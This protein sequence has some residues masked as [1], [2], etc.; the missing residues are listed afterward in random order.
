MITLASHQV[1]DCHSPY[2]VSKALGGAAERLN[3]GESS[4]SI[5][6]TSSAIYHVIE[7]Q[8]YSTIDD[9]KYEWKQGDTFAVPS[10]CKY[11]HSALGPDTVYLYRCDDF[12]ML[13]RLGFHRVEG[14]DPESLVSQ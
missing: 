11:Q 4:V 13:D 7:G 6:E 9:Q 2:S 1:A 12:P 5:R 8:G 14:V 3:S 10:W